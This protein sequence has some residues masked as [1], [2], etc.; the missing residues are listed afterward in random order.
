MAVHR[1]VRGSYEKLPSGARRGVISETATS[2]IERAP[3]PPG[4][5]WLRSPRAAVNPTWRDDPR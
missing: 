4:K 2:R 5:R 3:S 1:G